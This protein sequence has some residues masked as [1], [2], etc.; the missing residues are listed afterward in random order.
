MKKEHKVIFFVSLIA[1]G[2]MLTLQACDLRSFV[3]VDVPTSVL[4]ATGN[5]A[6][7][8]LNKSESLRQDWIYYVESNTKRLDESIDAAE[9][10][11]AEVHKILSIGLDTASTASNSIPYGGILFGALTGITGLMLPQPKFSRKKE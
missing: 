7:V 9:A 3:K 6:P 1:V 4:E 5:E 10:T 11:Y 2:I 8:T